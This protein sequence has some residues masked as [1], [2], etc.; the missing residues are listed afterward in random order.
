MILLD[1]CFCQG[2]G[3][4]KNDISLTSL[5]QGGDVRGGILREEQVQTSI[6]DSILRLCRLKW[7]HE[8]S[9]ISEKVAA[10]CAI[11]EHES[12]KPALR[13][14]RREIKAELIGITV[15]R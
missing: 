10:A 2:P 14:K 7:R 1:P 8:I 15:T 9:E 6:L 13:D 5:I 3:A 12:S 11:Y 4:F